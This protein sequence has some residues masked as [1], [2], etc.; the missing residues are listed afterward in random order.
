MPTCKLTERT[1]AKLA[2]PDPSNK[3]TLHWDSDLKGFGVLCSGTTSA[4]TYI[5]QRPLPN[6]RKR[7]V[8]IGACNV[9]ALID[10]RTKAKAV[11][12]D[13]FAGRDPKARKDR[14]T[15]A[16]ALE[17]YLAANKKLSANS[18][19]VYRHYVMQHL[20]QWLDLPLAAIT[21]D[22]VEQ[23][24]RKIAQTVAAGQG[25]TGH[26]T[27]NMTMKMLRILYNHVADAHPNMPANP[28]RRLRRQWYAVPHRTGLVKADDLPRFYEAVNALPPTA[29]DYLL[30]MLFTG[31]RRTEA[32]SL[33]WADVD[34]T[35][36]CIRIPAARTKAG[37]PLDLPMTDFVQDLLVAR[38]TLGRLQYIFPGNGKHGYFQ[39]LRY[40]LALLA[41]QTGI[42]ITAHDLRRTYITVAES[43]DISPLALKALVNHTLGGDVTAGYV[44]MTVERL[45]TP[46]QRVAD[47]LKELCGVVPPAGT[48]P[49]RATGTE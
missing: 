9:L 5:V 26:A 13:F 17:D 29:R 18:V 45:R 15:L 6:G 10:A 35:A 49:L 37:R 43:T 24:H 19:R 40:A 48:V 47:K 36:K 25:S 31:L 39:D 33:K 16:E 8:T 1:V 42:T 34:F 3:Q 30:L 41:K 14:T 4:K 11:L 7:R 23:R 28:V 21:S 20:T 46:A 44:Q 32:A 38:R 12:A 2:A 22:M 27:A